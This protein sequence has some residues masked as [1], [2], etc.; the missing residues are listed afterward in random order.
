[1][2]R[3]EMVGRVRALR[4]RRRGAGRS[5]DRGARLAPNGAGGRRFQLE[6]SRGPDR[7]GHGDRRDRCVPRAADP[8]GRGRLSLR[9]SRSSMRMTT[10]TPAN[11]PPGGVLIVGSG[12][13]G[14]QLAEELHEAGRAGRP[15]DRHVRR[16]AAP[17]PR[18][19]LSSGGSASSSSTA[20]PHD[21]PVPDGR[22]AAEPARQSS[23]ATR[24]CRGTAAATTR[25][26]GRWRL[27]GI[28]LAGRFA[29]A[30]GTIARFEPDLAANLQFA[31]EFFDR[32]VPTDHR[33]VRRTS[34]DRATGPDDRVWPSTTRR[35]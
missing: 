6:T 14:V 11:C 16:V 28:R 33:H 26:C 31:D 2:T 24:I 3:D 15:G 13:T 21:A 34:R 17:V 19:R 1:M 22:R 4:G 9:G 8:C 18:S 23:P 30:D 10:G 27:D 25:T 20:K 5:R 7:G 32:A 35:S 12:Q 29:G